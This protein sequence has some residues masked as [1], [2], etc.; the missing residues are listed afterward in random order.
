MHACI[1]FG[2]YI[3]LYAWKYFYSMHCLIFNKLFCFMPKKEFTFYWTSCLHFVNWLKN[4][5]KSVIVMDSPFRTA[6]YVPNVL[7]SQN[8]SEL[9]GSSLLV[10]RHTRLRTLCGA[11]DIVSGVT[12]TISL[13]F[14]LHHSP[15]RFLYNLL[16][17]SLMVPGC[18]DRRQSS[19]LYNEHCV[20]V[21]L[22]CSFSYYNVSSCGVYTR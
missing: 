18:C 5:L 21:Y 19:F 7:N 14:L 8:K 16:H 13:R 12:N 1:F 15:C 2:I 4:S 9:L 22:Q 3:N 17:F 11:V 10:G 6:F 20:T